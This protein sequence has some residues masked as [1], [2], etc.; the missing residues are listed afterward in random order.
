MTKM[1]VRCGCYRTLW[2]INI[3]DHNTWETRQHCPSALGYYHLSGRPRCYFWPLAFAF[4]SPGCGGHFE[5][6]WQEEYRNGD[7]SLFCLPLKLVTM[8]FK[9]PLNILIMLQ[10]ICCK[11][12]YIYVLFKIQT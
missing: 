3:L 6:N 9:W 12:Q 5:D 7:L 11:I 10:S 2:S 4:P 8:V 1:V